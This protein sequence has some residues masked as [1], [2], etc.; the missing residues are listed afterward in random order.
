VLISLADGVRNV[1]WCEEKNQSCS[2]CQVQGWLFFGTS[3]CRTF[4]TVCS[5]CN[6][7]AS[8]CV[9][10][11]QQQQLDGMCRGQHHTSFSTVE[12]LAIRTWQAQPFACSSEWCVIDNSDLALH[13][14]NPCVV[15]PQVQMCMIRMGHPQPH[16]SCSFVLLLQVL[17]V[18]WDAI[19]GTSP[20]T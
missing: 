9:W 1:S 6:V 15:A 13:M 14:C 16:P 8:V 11:W 5:F 4:L 2:A 7:L 10:S 3:T 17:I 20:T 19:S 12:Q 18:Q